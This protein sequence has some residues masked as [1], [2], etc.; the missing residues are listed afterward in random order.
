MAIDPSNEE[1]EAD[2]APPGSSRM[3]AKAF[4]D[5]PGVEDWRV[6][7]WGAHAFYLT[8]SFAEAARFV[9]AIADVAASVGHDPDVDVRPEGVTV[10]TFSRSDGALSG[11]DAELAALVSAQAAELGL[12]AD[13]SQ[14]KVVGI[15]VAQ[16]EGVDT[17]P[18]WTAALGYDDLGDEDAID[19]QRRGPHLWFHALDPSVPGRGRTHIDVS[20]P[21]EVAEQ[22]VEAALAAGGRVARSNA[23]HWWTLASPD[24][25]G[26]DIAAWPDF[27]DHDEGD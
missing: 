26:V 1:N 14:L 17:R 12:R 21:R 16:H 25:H 8:A 5:S 3:T 20:V 4:H 22:R 2:A 24:N 10:R 9:T 27:E 6:L 15:A 13:P 19:P 11:V 23:P 18:F 7:F